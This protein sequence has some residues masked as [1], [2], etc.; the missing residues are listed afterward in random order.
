[1][2]LDSSD[3]ELLQVLEDQSVALHQG[4]S[5]NVRVSIPAG[6]RLDSFL[7]DGRYKTT[8][9]VRSDHSAADIRRQYETQIG[10]APDTPDELRPASGYVVHPDWERRAEEKFSE[11]TGKEAN[12]F[13]EVPTGTA[14]GVSIYGNVQLI[15]RPEVAER[16][17]YGYGDSLNTMIRPARLDETDPQRI[18][19][20]IVSSDGKD[21]DSIDSLVM[22]LLES[23]RT[24]SFEKVNAPDGGAADFTDPKGFSGRRYFEALIPG[25]FGVEDVAAVKIAYRDLAKS[26]TDSL[27][28]FKDAEERT[29]Q[30]REEFFAVDK[31]RNMGFSEEEIQYITGMLDNYNWSQKGQVAI[32]PNLLSEIQELLDFR[33]AKSRKEIIESKG[34]KVMPLHPTSEDPFNPAFYGGKTSDNVEQIL[35]D[36]FYSTFPTK[37]RKERE[38]KERLRQ[39]E[40]ERIALGIEEDLSA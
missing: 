29:Q 12:E 39:E 28:A 16:T 8:H 35:L 17:G 22:S 40:A 23:S 20:A 38:M 14:G 11:A 32:P 15:L 13:S 26:A 9:E 19:A 30:I 21:S 31:L 5:R 7:S 34:I 27:D 3:E 10:I 6:A 24:G 1:M 2:I 36:R 4:M 18:F 33:Q 25:S 37:V